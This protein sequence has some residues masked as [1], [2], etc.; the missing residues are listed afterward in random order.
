MDSYQQARL[1]LEHLDLRPGATL[2]D[3]KQAYRTLVQ[4]WHPDRFAK[5]TAIQ[6]KAEERFKDVTAA[7][8]WLSD[9]PRILEDLVT[10][11]GQE[12]SAS[13]SSSS[14]RDAATPAEPPSGVRKRWFHR[15]YH[16]PIYVARGW[17]PHVRVPWV[18]LG[19][20]AVGG[21]ILLRD[22]DPYDGLLRPQVFQNV[23]DAIQDPR[24]EN[25]WVYDQRIDIRKL[26]G[27]DSPLAG[28]LRRGERVVATEAVDGW[29]K[30]ADFASGAPLGWV[31]DTEVGTRPPSPVRTGAQ[32]RADSVS[33][34]PIAA[35]ERPAPSETGEEAATA[36]TTEVAAVAGALGVS[37]AP[38]G[39]SQRGVGEPFKAWDNSVSYF[40][41]PFDVPRGSWEF[42][43]KTLDTGRVHVRLYALER[44]QLKAEFWHDSVSV[45]QFDFEGGGSY[46]VRIV[47]P[48]VRWE[49]RVEGH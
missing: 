48:G 34:A 16:K 15:R 6:F 35:A 46:Q 24:P 36:G 3:V 29:R 31:R 21:Y 43:F 26:P 40:T 38:T 41:Q 2:E 39:S 10:G 11:R 14:S 27:T 30:I 49:A 19:A 1:C 7:Y 8:A 5:G 45:T 25:L 33:L 20:A 23:A 22:R 18:F 4:V 42:V 17:I 12:R 44:N 28:F 13:G 37:A 47:S 9:N 32:P